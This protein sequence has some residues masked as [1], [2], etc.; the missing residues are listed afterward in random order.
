MAQECFTKKIFLLARSSGPELS[1]NSG[2]FVLE[3]VLG[4]L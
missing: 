4:Y 3:W 1:D 2:R